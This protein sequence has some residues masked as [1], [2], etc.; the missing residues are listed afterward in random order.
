MGIRLSVISGTTTLAGRLVQP[1]PEVSR[2]N[3]PWGVKN[4]RC[5]FALLA[6]PVKGAF[7]LASIRA[8]SK[9]N[10]SDGQAGVV[11]LESQSLSLRTDQ[12]LLSILNSMA[13]WEV[14]A[15]LR[16]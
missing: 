4:N 12:P 7:S 13:H 2:Y 15:R 16:V 10:G 5:R 11:V 8:V 3:R 6:S 1:E 14:T 9:F